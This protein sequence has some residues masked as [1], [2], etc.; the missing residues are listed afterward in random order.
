MQLSGL[1]DI[2]NAATAGELEERQPPA[3]R[4]VERA[5]PARGKPS[6]P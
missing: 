4:E 1:P 2:A 3:Q 5:F 6:H